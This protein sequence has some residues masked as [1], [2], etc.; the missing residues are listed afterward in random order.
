MEIKTEIMNEVLTFFL[1]SGRVDA[2]TAPQLEKEVLSILSVQG[3]ACVIDLE[4]VDFMSSAGLRVLLLCSKT[5]VTVKGKFALCGV[6][7]NI[8]KLLETI[9]FLPLLEIY[10]DRSSASDAISKYFS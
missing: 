8:R 4:N 9:G 5:S 10:A 2:V 6:Q 3:K 1:V 7:E